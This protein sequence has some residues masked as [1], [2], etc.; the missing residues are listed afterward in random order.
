MGRNKHMIE[1]VSEN[2]VDNLIEE[3]SKY[4]ISMTK[5]TINHATDIANCTSALAELISAKAL[6]T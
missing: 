5:S 2:G 6:R 4:I 1:K 3:L